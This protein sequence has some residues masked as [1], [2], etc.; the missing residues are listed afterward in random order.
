MPDWLA[1]K[2]IRMLVQFALDKQSGAARRAV[3]VSTSPR[4]R[5]SGRSWPSGRRPTRWDGRSL[6]R[7]ARRRSAS[8]SCAAP[9]RP[10]MKDPQLVAEAQ[11]EA[12][13]RQHRR[14]RSRPVWSTSSIRCRRTSSPRR[15]RP[16][17]RASA[18]DAIVKSL[19]RLN[20]SLQ[21][22]LPATT[23]AR[24]LC[25]KTKCG[26]RS[27]PSRGAGRML[28]AIVRDGAAV[29]ARAGRCRRRLL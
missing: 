11:D 20:P 13:G 14:R 9:S 5:S 8:R 7:P 4:P 12:R 3:G 2:K 6:R 22:P 29:V 28:A 16:R 1:E 17:G 23:A 10:T 19:R 21:L 18:C 27:M 24:K 25:R 26:E 15:R